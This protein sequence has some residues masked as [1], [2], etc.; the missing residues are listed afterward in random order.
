MFVFHSE[1]PDSKCIKKVEAAT[2]SDWLSIIVMSQF[3]QISIS[4]WSFLVL[5]AK[6]MHRDCQILTILFMTMAF[7]FPLVKL[8]CLTYFILRTSTFFSD[9][10]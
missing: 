8:Q 7:G 1:P 3:L 2:K 10:I 9:T 4:T 6:I 5:A